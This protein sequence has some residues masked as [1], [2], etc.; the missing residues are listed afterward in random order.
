ML[1]P[2][3]SGDV[4]GTAGPRRRGRRNGRSRRAGDRARRL[5]VRRRSSR[6]RPAPREGDDPP[7]HLDEGAGQRQVRPAGVGGDVEEDQPALAERRGGDQ[8]RAVGECRPGA[9]GKRR[10]RVR[11]AP[12][13]SRSRRRAPSGRRRGSCRRSSP[14]AA[15]SAR[16]GCRRARGR[17]GAASPGSARRSPRPGAAGEAHQHAAVAAPS[18]RPVSSTLVVR[19]PMSAMAITEA[20]GVDQLGHGHGGIGVRG[21]RTSAKGCTAREM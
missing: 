17:R 10:R 14:A 12:A 3:R 15:A 16:R 2:G 5:G 9:S 21:S 7:Q 20:A 13:A 8:R 1:G 18:W 6:R 19:V 4:A 11:P